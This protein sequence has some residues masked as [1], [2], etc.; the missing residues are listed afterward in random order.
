MGV[1]FLAWAALAAAKATCSA[2]HCEDGFCEDRGCVLQQGGLVATKGTKGRF[3]S[4]T[5]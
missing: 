4:C 5:G 2:Q 1:S 3:E